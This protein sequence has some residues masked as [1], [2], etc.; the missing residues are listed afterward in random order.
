VAKREGEAFIEVHADTT[1]FPREAERGI[2]A[3]SEQVEGD[4]KHTGD[5]WGETLTGAMGDRLEREGPHLAK[6]VEKGINKQKVKVPVR[7]EYDRDRS[8]VRRTVDKVFDDIEEAVREAASGGGSGGGPLGKV[9]QAFSDA[10]GAGFNVSGKSPLIAFIVPLVGAII[11]LVGAAIQA[12]S[13]LAAVAITLPGILASVGIQVGVLMLAFKGVGTAV[14]GAFAANNAKELKEALKDLQPAAQAFVKELLPLKDFFHQ[15]QGQ[16]QQGFFKELQGVFTSIYRNLG[17]SIFDGF[18]SV[19]KALGAFLANL[20][21]FLA[22]GGSFK[23]FLDEIFPRTVTF[24]EQF[25]PA[26][27]TFLDGLLNMVNAAMPF[28]TKVG[29]IVSMIFKQVGDAF[30]EVASDPDFI[31]WL[32]RMGETLMSV[33]Q[34]FRAAGIFIGALF[35]AVDKAGGQELIDKFSEALIMLAVFLTSDT[36]VKGLAALF[37]IAIISIQTITAFIIVAVA[38]LAAIRE[39]LIF[40]KDIVLPGIVDFFGA[41]GSAIGSFFGWIGTKLKE[42]WDFLWWVF[43][44]G[45]IN[46]VMGSITAR[47]TAI[48]AFISGWAGRVKDWFA[49][50]PD[51]I[52]EAFSNA[53]SFLY[54]AGRNIIQ[55]LI[56]GVKD[57]IGSLRN[58]LGNVGGIISGF[59]PHSPA[60]EGPLSGKGDPRV[61]G[62]TIIQRLATGMEMETPTLRAASAEATQNIVFGPNS[63]QMRIN[64]TMDRDQA[65]IAG[66]GVAEGI[67][68]NLNRDTRLA[69]RSL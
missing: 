40:M 53:M 32:D 31:D 52:K 29:D 5:K 54:N 44:G 25:G 57:M 26:F 60:E 39:F 38:A 23:K 7:V 41:A 55:G 48:G 69:I 43:V 24:L 58:A 61:S 27:I 8:G 11:G 12:L 22:T 16:V 42:L 6:S 37:D 1:P 46:E 21:K 4:L 59:F 18:I 15:L 28:L 66:A 49:S 33:V 67:W 51:R 34:L 65:R 30:N 45:G 10:L 62:Q 3:G 35:D 9:G 17:P 20:G 14:Q 36:G 13:A 47:F 56:N 68:S 19:A 50:I 64:G 63:I 2:R